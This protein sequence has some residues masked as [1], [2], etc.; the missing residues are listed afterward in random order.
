MLGARVRQKS[1]S[2]PHCEKL[3][4][5]ASCGALL[6][7]CERHTGTQDCHDASA[8]TRSRNP[9]KIFYNKLFFKHVIYGESETISEFYSKRS[10]TFLNSTSSSIGVTSEVPERPVESVAMVRPQAT[11]TPSHPPRAPAAT[12]AVETLA[13]PD[14]IAMAV[15]IGQVTGSSRQV[16]KLVLRTFN[17]SPFAVHV[18]KIASS[19]RLLRKHRFYLSRVQ[20]F[21]CYIQP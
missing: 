2:H 3:A 10:V 14:S 4:E 11:R 16:Y 9:F 18:T 7:G 19:Q 21:G 12:A 6:V 13:T 1:S 15:R 20:S 5:P 17:K 8:G